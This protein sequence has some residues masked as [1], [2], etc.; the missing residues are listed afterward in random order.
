[1]TETMTQF[2]NPRLNRVT[3]ASNMHTTLIWENIAASASACDYCYFVAEVANVVQGTSVVSGLGVATQLSLGITYFSFGE[4][5][6]I[7]PRPE[8]ITAYTFSDTFV[9]QEQTL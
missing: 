1:M 2:N 7:S 4:D 6:T 9:F 5:R 8:P 3:S